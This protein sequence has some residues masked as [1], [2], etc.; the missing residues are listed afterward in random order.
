MTE[1]SNQ[2]PETPRSEV[3]VRDF[4]DDHPRYASLIAL[5]LL[6]LLSADLYVSTMILSFGQK[7][8][9]LAFALTDMVVLG[10]LFGR[11]I[12]RAEESWE[13]FCCRN[14][15]LSGRILCLMGGIAA[16]LMLCGQTSSDVTS[17]IGVGMGLLAFCLWCFRNQALAAR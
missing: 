2:T 6:A 3:S 9:V 16:V 15:Q 10:A 8:G 11:K 4:L 17:V 7:I 13:A 1:I 5:G 14:V 12:T